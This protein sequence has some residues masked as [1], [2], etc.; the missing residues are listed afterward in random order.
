MNLV[1]HHRIKG[2]Q[3]IS[4]IVIGL[5]TQSSWNPCKIH[6][7]VNVH[8]SQFVSI[9]NMSIM[10]VYSHKPVRNIKWRLLF[11]S[12][13]KPKMSGTEISVESTFVRVAFCDLV[14]HLQFCWSGM[15]LDFKLTYSQSLSCSLFCSDLLI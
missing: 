13:Y 15:S 7:N 11:T 14:G 1:T 5:K 4:A 8:K 10:T 12:C 3:Q 9:A 2:W 6:M